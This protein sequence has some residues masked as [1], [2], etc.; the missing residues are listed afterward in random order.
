MVYVR[1]AEPRLVS[2]RPS[3]E[4]AEMAIET[5]TEHGEPDR[6]PD[7]ERDD[8]ALQAQADAEQAARADAAL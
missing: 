6:E 2:F 8:S 7:P 3:P 5:I 1:F 4:E